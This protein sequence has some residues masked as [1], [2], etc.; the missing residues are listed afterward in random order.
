M[1]ISVKVTKNGPPMRAGLARALPI[2][3]AGLS[4]E[5]RD[6]TASGR[7]A[8]GRPFKRHPDGAPSDLKRTGAMVRSFGPQSVRAN[9]FTLA[10]AKAHQWK[11]N[12]N[13]RGEGARPR[14]QW[15]G[16]D[17]GQIDRAVDQIATAMF[18]PRKG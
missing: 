15:I 10:P 11:A 5:I 12:V 8:N 9:G 16:L 3:A 17:G 6:R 13:Q 1:K 4:S 18:G 2:L 14:R 7:D